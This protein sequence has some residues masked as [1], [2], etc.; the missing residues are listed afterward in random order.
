MFNKF[1]GDYDP[2]DTLKT[3]HQDLEELKVKYEGLKKNQLVIDSKLDD[4]MRAVQIMPTE[5]VEIPHNWS[6]HDK[7]EHSKIFDE[8]HKGGEFKTNSMQIKTVL[9]R[10]Q[11]RKR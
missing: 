8:D 2:Y 5:N 7:S 11:H 4:I 3:V 9:R 10:L 1:I 6:S